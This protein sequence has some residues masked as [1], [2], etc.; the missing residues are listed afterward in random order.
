MRPTT[1]SLALTLSLVVLSCSRSAA[2]PE[3]EAV[4]RRIAS[5]TVLSDEILWALGDEVHARVVGI[6]PMADDPRYSGVAGLWPPDMPRL[7]HNPEELIATGAE[8]VIVASFSNAEYRAAIADHAELLV[9][10]DFSGFAGYLDNLARIGEAVGATPAAIATVRERFET[11][12]ARLEAARP[13]ADARPSVIAW[14]AGQVPGARTTF[15]D[16]ARCAGFDNLA[17]AQGLVG[18]Q[19]VD[20][21][22]L[23]AWDPAWLVI[24]CGERACADAVDEFAEQPGFAHLQ[25]VR[26]GHVIAIEAPALGSVGEGM[27]DAAARMQAALLEDAR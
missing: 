18:H 27:L 12:R 5:R 11:R 24:G 6:S 3:R 4:P 23:V 26:E 13:P 19:R 9:L 7:G 21:E 20:A 22:Q 2:E 1:R 8:L 15:D 17:S 16:I 14:E 25:A 10:D